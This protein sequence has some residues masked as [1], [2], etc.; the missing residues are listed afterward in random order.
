MTAG[1]YVRHSLFPGVVKSLYDESCAVCGLSVRAD[2]G[3]LVDAAHIMPFHLFHN[4][5]PRNGIA[6]CKNHHWGFDVGWYA[7]GDDYKLIVS[8]QLQNGIGYVT[9]GALLRLPGLPKLA[10]A[11]EA[12]AWHRSHKFLH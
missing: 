9:A 8:P 10:P 3:G 1:Y 11:Q 12:L 2:K 7:I 4:D 5:D 6:F